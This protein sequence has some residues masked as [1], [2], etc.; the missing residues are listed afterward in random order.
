VAYR[1]RGASYSASH[2]TGSG[3][4]ITGGRW[5]RKDVAIVYTACNIALA[6]LETF[7]HIDKTTVLPLN[8]FP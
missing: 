2:M 6:V 8:R 1:H 5:N 4:K 7:V 3:P